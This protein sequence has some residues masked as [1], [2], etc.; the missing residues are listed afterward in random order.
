MSEFWSRAPA[1]SYATAL[2]AVALLGYL[3]GRRRMLAAAENGAIARREIERAQAVAQQLEKIAA[4][5]GGEL[6]KHHTSVARFKQ[7]V[8]E[9]G[10]QERDGAW[11]KLCDEAE[12]MLRPT[13]QLANEFAR[14]YDEIRY[15]TSHLMAFADVRTDALTGVRNR[16]ALDECLAGLLALRHRYNQPFAVVIL[17]VDHFKKINDELGHLN[18]DH[19]LRAVAT[20][21]DQAVRETDT[22]ARFGGEEFVIVL[23]HTDL[24]GGAVFAERLRQTVATQNLG[25]VRV[26]VSMGLATPLEGENAAGVLTRADEALYQAKR[27]GRDRV[28][29]H[30]G[31]QIVPAVETVP[32][33]AAPNNATPS[34][35]PPVDAASSATSLPAG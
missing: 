2:A 6:S 22:V 34:E 26:T 21:L 27:A 10:D 20:L 18:G 1:L 30:T 24:E 17:D 19:V 23:P 13:L 8:T 7:R 14:A 33:D 16:R 11:K 25:G 29:R 3:I 32:S 4:V 35:T 15:Q 12:E 9:L 31:T 28:Y 5:V